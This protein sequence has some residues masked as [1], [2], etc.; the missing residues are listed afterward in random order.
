VGILFKHQEDLEEA[1]KGPRRQARPEPKPEPRAEPKM[2]SK[3]Q[4]PPESARVEP[5]LEKSEPPVEVLKPL[6]IPP[7]PPEDAKVHVQFSVEQFLRLV[8]GLPVK[9]NAGLVLRVVEAT[10][11]SLDI[12]ISDILPEINRREGV[13]HDRIEAVQRRLEDL[14]MELVER[15]S[16]LTDLEAELAET[17]NLRNLLT[18]TKGAGAASRRDSSAE[19]TLVLASNSNRTVN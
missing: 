16:E 3:V 14:E 18:L 6:L 19:E 15:R 4:P 10:L 13:V 1:A 12:Q 5:R 7:P 2:E 9:E 17:Q 11:G 8:H